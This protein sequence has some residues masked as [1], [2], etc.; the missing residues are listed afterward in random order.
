MKDCVQNLLILLLII[1][2]IF[3]ITK[4]I[5]NK[6]DSFNKGLKLQ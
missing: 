3:S 4:Y 5:K 1:V 6:H 2:L